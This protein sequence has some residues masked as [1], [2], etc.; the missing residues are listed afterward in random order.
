MEQDLG[1]KAWPIYQR[2]AT[3][4]LYLCADVLLGRPQCDGLIRPIE[5][6]RQVTR[7]GQLDPNRR[8]DNIPSWCYTAMS[9][10]RRLTTE[11]K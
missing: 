3:S 4:P 5:V 8:W 9:A 1:G 2:V 6:K 7:L 10:A 11:L